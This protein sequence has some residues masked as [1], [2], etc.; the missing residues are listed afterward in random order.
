MI[1]AVIDPENQTAIGQI[2]QPVINRGTQVN[3]VSQV[4]QL[5][6]NR[7]GQTAT[8]QETPVDQ[9]AVNQVSQ[10]NQPVVDRVSQL[11]TDQENP[12]DQTVMTHHD[13]GIQL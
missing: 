13:Q 8:D 3:Q 6:I 4:S 12:V 1:T 7:V 9:T 10:V 5:A 11:A 2:A